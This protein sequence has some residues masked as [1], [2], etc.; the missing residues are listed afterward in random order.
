MNKVIF[1]ILKSKLTK[2]RSVAVA[3]TQKLKDSSKARLKN[4]SK[5]VQKI[6]TPERQQQEQQHQA[7]LAVVMNFW[8][9]TYQDGP[10]NLTK[11]TATEL[12]R[13]I[14]SL[15]EQAQD[16]FA[17]DFTASVM[18]HKIDNDYTLTATDRANFSLFISCYN[19]ILN[20]RSKRGLK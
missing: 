11:E 9:S 8:T 5:A 13:K 20:D 4:G 18:Q 16:L 10:S 6:N 2:N 14:E 19:I 3:E 12:A 7:V 17:L 1:E 15:L